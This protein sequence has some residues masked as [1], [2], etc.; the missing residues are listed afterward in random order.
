[1]ATQKKRPS[2]DEQI[3][4]DKAKKDALALT[5]ADLARSGLDE[6]A[7]KAMGLQS[8]TAPETRQA[9]EILSPSYYIPYFH[10]FTGAGWHGRYRLTGKP[11]KRSDEKRICG[12]CK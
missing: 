2:L 7:A 1:M 12:T 3:K 6:I 10:P 8:L 5:V 4:A 9:C 11:A